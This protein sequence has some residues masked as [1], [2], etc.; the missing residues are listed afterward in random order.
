MGPGV[1]SVPGCRDALT[2]PA[3]LRGAGTW[4]RGRLGSRSG[5]PTSC[6]KGESRGGGTQVSS[7]PRWPRLSHCPALCLGFP[8][9][10]VRRVVLRPPEGSDT[11]PPAAPCA[12][13]AQ[14]LPG[15]L[16]TRRGGMDFY[17]RLPVIPPE[18]GK[19]R[20]RCKDLLP[21]LPSKPQA[22]MSGDEQN[23]P[24]TLVVR[25]SSGLNASGC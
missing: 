22:P 24:R 4:T 17:P 25:T 7:V 16:L 3:S 13:A 20:A 1:K 19:P 2:H 11:P 10:K 6:G 9:C 18:E 12:P 15:G 8:V 5:S 21:S 14:V 23:Q